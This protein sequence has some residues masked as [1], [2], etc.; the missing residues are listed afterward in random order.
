MFCASFRCMADTLNPTPPSDAIL[1]LLPELAARA[2]E[3]ED[4][5]RLPADLAG[6]LAAAGVFRMVTLEPMAASNSPHARLWR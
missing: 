3:M 2:A 5:R 4:A 6:K 1:P